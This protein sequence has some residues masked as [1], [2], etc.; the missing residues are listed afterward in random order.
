M[1]LSRN[2]RQT[3]I[4]TDKQNKQNGNE[5]KIEIDTTLSL[6]NLSSTRLPRLSPFCFLFASLSLCCL[7]VSFPP[8]FL[9]VFQFVVRQPFS[10]LVSVSV[11]PCA[12]RADP[13]SYYPLLWPPRWPS[14]SG[15]RLESGR[16]RVRI[17]LTPGFF[18]GSSHTSD[19]KIDTTVATLPAG[20][21]AR[22]Q[23]TVT[24]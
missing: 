13:L 16:S 2:H 14:S 17:P 4:Q 24:G 5:C 1:N 15:V 18:S 20:T 19:L 10:L 21:S 7:F 6:L 9:A 3:N 12:R 8:K 11:C 23:C 22:C